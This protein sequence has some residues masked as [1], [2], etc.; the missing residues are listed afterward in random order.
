MTS[1]GLLMTSDDLSDCAPHQVLRRSEP[2]WTEAKK[3]MGDPGFLNQLIN[4]DKDSLNDQVLQK[5]SK[6]TKEADFDPVV[7]GGISV[8]C[9]SMC[10][11]VRAMEVY[12]KIAKDVAPKRAKL[13]AAIRGKL[14]RMALAEEALA[15]QRAIDAL[16]MAVTHEA[17]EVALLFVLVQRLAL[18]GLAQPPQGGQVGEALLQRACRRKRFDASAKIQALVRAK[19]ARRYMSAL[20]VGQQACDRGDLDSA[21]NHFRMAFELSGSAWPAILATNMLLLHG[22]P[23]AAI[24]EYE[25]LLE[26]ALGHP[27]FLDEAD[28][29][30]V[31]RRLQET[32]A[33]VASMATS[34]LT[35]PMPG[36]RPTSGDGRG[37]G[38]GGYDPLKHLYDFANLNLAS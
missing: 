38:K 22:E 4:F 25:R 36:F 34:E 29:A 27:N 24:E 23:D 30:A 20:W 14:T 2:S 35:M 32:R 15:R 5:V 33:L 18:Q 17:V 21:R 7:V 28:K 19:A 11:W 26:T 16:A 31:Q 1:D 3:Q 13:Q 6:Y 37:R 10:L 8:A 12:G 9:K